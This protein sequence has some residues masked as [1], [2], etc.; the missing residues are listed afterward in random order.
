MNKK[1][2]VILLLLIVAA[3][4]MSAVSAHEGMENP[5]VPDPN[6]VQPGD[7]V[8]GTVNMTVD[9]HWHNERNYVNFSAEN[10]ETRTVYWN[11]QDLNPSDGWSA[12][13]DTSDVPNGDYWIT[14]TAVDVKNLE[15]KK[16]FKLVLNNVPT[17]SNI[18]LENVT[19]VVDKSTNIVATLNDA[20]F[21]PIAD[22]SVE[23]IIDG[24][25][26]STKTTSS[27]VA[28]IPF[29]PVEVKNYEIIVKFNGDNKYLKS[30]AKG[31]IKVL[32]NVNATVLAV[33]NIVG[34]NKEKI[35]LKANLLCPG[36]L[37]ASYNKKIDFYVNGRYVG[38][39]LTDD[40]GD[41]ILHYDITEI[42]GDYVYQ[43]RYQNENGENF[44]DSALLHVPQ[45]EVYIAMNAV[46]YSSDG[47][48]TIGNRFK[49]NLIVNNNGP[50]SAQDTVVT[51][52]VPA[53]IKYIESNASQGKV[54]YDS[55]KGTLIWNVGNVTKGSQ[56]IELVFQILASGRISLSPQIT[57]VTYDES[58]QNA[59]P[60]RFLTV[61]A[62]ELKSNALTKYYGGSEKYRVYLYTKDGK[63]VS[64]AIIRISVKKQTFNLKTNVNGFVEL[65]VDLKSGKYAVEVNCNNLHISNK[66]VIKPTLIT[67]NI[68]KKKSKVIK[69]TAKVL[70]NK[71][72]PI[73]NKKVI[74]KVK[75]KK[76]KVKTNKKGVATLKLKNLKVGKYVVYTSYGKLSQKNIIRIK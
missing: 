36:L 18:V 58:I 27:G 57:T 56:N 19:A 35:L 61:N 31:L 10:I 72:K 8:S 42:G 13:W 20:D 68:V 65:A 25:T 15:G 29:T 30:Q 53:Q 1:L 38:S 7:E 71:G 49:L 76:Y 23:F 52:N 64:G 32:S 21:N 67:K 37:D 59:V 17:Q 28:T 60:A 40:N 47:I 24:K 69:Y 26:C 33:D 74:F 63:P 43:A 54:T 55:A 34:N 2:M 51:Y 39:N 45:S 66:I 50:D 70:N 44:T 46:T 48:F 22:K 11:K 73:K 75:G 3:C 14:I 16:E 6:E 5:I 62:Y 12:S 4:L 9:V 41:A